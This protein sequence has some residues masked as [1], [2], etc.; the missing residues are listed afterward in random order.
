[1]FMKIFFLVSKEN[2]P[3]TVSDNPNN[4]NFKISITEKKTVAN[5]AV[6]MSCTS[7][8]ISKMYHKLTLENDQ[9]LPQID[10]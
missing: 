2:E 10:D 6:V 7:H 3:F 9:L 5:V 4:K 1:M 8:L